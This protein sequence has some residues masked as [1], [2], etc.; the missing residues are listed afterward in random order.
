MTAVAQAPRPSAAP[1]LDAVVQVRQGGFLLDVALQADAGQVVAVVGPNGAGKSTLLRVLAGLLPLT[2]GRVVLAG[3]AIADAAQGL[4]L[5]PYERSVGVL[6]Q[7]YRLFPH[8]SA[9]DNVA[10][11]LRAQGMPRRQARAAADGW[12]SRLDLDGLGDRRPPAL[13]GGQAQRVALGRALAVEPAL[14]LLD[15]PLAALDAGARAAVRADLRRHL[16]AFPGPALLVTH[17]PLE[18]MTLADRLVVLERGRVVQSGPPAEVARRPRTAYVGSL[19]GLNVYRGVAADGVL[20]V[21][22]GGTVRFAG[23]VDGRVAAA[24]RPSAVT[25][26]VAPPS[27]SSSRNTWSGVLEALEPFGDRV[28]ATVRADLPLLADVAVG[29]VAELRLEPG[30]TVWASVEATD[31]DVYPEDQ[32]APEA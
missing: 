29:A 13:S 26:H 14:L 17:D 25:L 7:D 19:V 8:L 2:S 20:A 12:L 10:F 32:A 24:L 30:A 11:G 3:R 4:H 5:P 1:A 23:N 27:A 18:A 28:R 16:V 15:E 9:R 22:A 6:F 21:D 31:V